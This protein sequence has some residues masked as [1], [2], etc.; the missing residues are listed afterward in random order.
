MKNK[1]KDCLFWEPTDKTCLI[2]GVCRHVQ[3][4]NCFDYEEDIEIE[5]EEE[6]S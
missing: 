6:K 2:N 1:I 5:D 4:N 3:Q